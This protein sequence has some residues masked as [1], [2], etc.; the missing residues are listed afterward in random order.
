M[1][2]ESKILFE[3]YKR[4]AFMLPPEVA[5]NYTLAIAEFIYSSHI[6]Q[7]FKSKVN[8]NPI[9]KLNILFPNHLGL[10]AGFD[11]NGDFLNFLSGIGFGFI[12][13]GTVTPKPQPGNKKP[14]VFRL[15]KENAVINHL[16]F[17]N[18]GIIHLKKNLVSHLDK[19]TVPIG[20]NIGKNANTHI[21][22]A[23]ED[24]I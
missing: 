20:V 6:G 13:I 3:I 10:A 7:F 18:K 5:H 23:H 2:K 17:N 12:E 19:K 21:T 9:K 24:Y 11:K 16:G 14:R 4:I 8:Q 1:I 22:E 15:I